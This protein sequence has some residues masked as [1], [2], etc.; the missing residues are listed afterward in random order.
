VA[1]Q[2]CPY[3]AMDILFVGLDGEILMWEVVAVAID[4]ADANLQIVG[5]VDEVLLSLIRN[6]EIKHGSIRKGQ[7][8]IDIAMTYEAIA[9]VTRRLR[10]RIFV[11][12]VTPI[13]SL[14]GR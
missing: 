1:I 8:L 13:L 9:I 5:C 6:L 12:A 2:A 7:I 4:T 3:I 10:F 14:H 11:A